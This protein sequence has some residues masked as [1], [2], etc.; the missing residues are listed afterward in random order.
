MENR[1]YN[2]KLVQPVN[3]SKYPARTKQEMRLIDKKPFRDT[4]R[5]RV[6]NYLDCKPKNKKEQHFGAL[7]GGLLGLAI[8][9]SVAGAILNKSAQNV[10]PKNRQKYTKKY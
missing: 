2:P 3:V 8:T 1:K 6:P 9:A 5:D 7:L 4:D 10:N